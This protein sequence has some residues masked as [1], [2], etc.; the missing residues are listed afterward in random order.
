MI[1]LSLVTS[2]KSIGIFLLAAD[3]NWPSV[4]SNLQ[5]A[6]RKWAQTTRVLGRESADDQT[7]DQLY[8]AA[9]QLDMFYGSEMWVI[10]PHIGRVLVGFHHRV[11]HKMKGGQPRK[12]RDGVWI[13]PLLEEAMAETELQGVDTYVSCQQ[14]KSEQFIVSRPIMDLCLAAERRPGTRVSNQWWD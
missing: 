10:T 2:F 12:G 8:L 3:D 7:L 11:A 13:Y 1:S 14:K 5:K 9:V 6:R 4:V